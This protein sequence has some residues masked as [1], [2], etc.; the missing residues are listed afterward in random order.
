LIISYPSKI[1][2]SG[3]SI[4][5]TVERE[6]I[7]RAPDSEIHVERLAVNRGQIEMWNLPTR[8]TKK[9]DTRA[10][11]FRRQH[12]T[13]SVELDAI[14]PDELRQ[15]VKDAIDSHMDPWAL[16]VLKV[17]EEEERQTLQS[18]FANDKGGG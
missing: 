15:L 13:D 1:H 2:P 16:K 8:P 11:T 4:A 14:P 10:A 17:A 12:G 9:S 3:V 5:A 7:R 18:I 6:L